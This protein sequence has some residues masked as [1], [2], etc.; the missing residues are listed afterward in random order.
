MNTTL[1]A[2]ARSFCVLGFLVWWTTCSTLVV[3][4]PNYR[5]L[6]SSQNYSS[7]SSDRM[8]LLNWMSLNWMPICSSYI[9][10]SVGAIKYAA[11]S[12]QC[13]KP[14][15]LKA[16]DCYYDEIRQSLRESGPTLYNKPLRTLQ[17]AVVEIKERFCCGCCPSQA[18]QSCKEARGLNYCLQSKAEC[19]SSLEIIMKYSKAQT[20][21]WGL[22]TLRGIWSCFV[23]FLCSVCCS[24]LL[25]MLFL[26][27][28][29][30]KLHT[31]F[32]NSGR[33]L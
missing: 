22:V 23:C 11:G 8:E 21:S 29:E 18:L 20:H 4:A 19:G 26:N 30:N 7:Q 1:T 6:R 2:T 27:C 32:G 28:R 13:Y 31:R 9:F 14:N 12:M 16:P 33:Q 25:Y 24:H 17:N 5:I 10:L 15:R 3:Y